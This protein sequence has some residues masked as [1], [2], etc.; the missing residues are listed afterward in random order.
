MKEGCGRGQCASRQMH[1]GR[2]E[3]SED[4]APT[5]VLGEDVRGSVAEMYMHIFAYKQRSS[6]RES[7]GG[8]GAGEKG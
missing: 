5:W 7:T 4:V 3:G 8:G 1:V 6:F 2:A